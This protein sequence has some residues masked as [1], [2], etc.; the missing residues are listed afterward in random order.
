MR[1]W[2]ELSDAEFGE[3]IR[4]FIA[5][6]CPE[7]L[8]FPKRRLR[9][10]EVREWYL[11]L[12][13]EGMLAP[14]WPAEYG[15][16]GL[17]PGKALVFMETMEVNGAPRLPD[18]GIINLG[19][20]LIKH[21]NDEQ[22]QRYLPK[23]LSGEHLWCQG[24][25]EPNSGSD[26]ASLRTSAVLDGE[27]YVVNGQKIWTTWAL[28]AT[29]IFA[30]VRTDT[31]VAKQAGISFL[32]IG[33]DQPGITIR[34]IENILGQSE[35]CQ[36]FFDNARTHRSNL[37]GGVNSGWN[38]AKAL[39]GFERIWAGSPRQAQLFLAQIEDYARASGKLQDA[40]WRERIV[41]LRLDI[42]DL[43]ALYASFA[44]QV[45][46]GETLGAD[47]SILKIW[48]TE[49]CQRMSELLVDISG[50]LGTIVR[51]E[52]AASDARVPDVVTP[53]LDTRSFTIYGGTSEVQRNIV[54]RNVLD[55]LS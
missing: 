29:H 13:S 30:L 26:L 19:P 8:R 41:Q 6:H 49:T 46:R 34:P 48:A 5:R 23:I 21:G 51:D 18:Q 45:R 37:V 33:L 24:Y 53:F 9:W 11:A 50:E 40:A 36:V 14:N 22:R 16:M 1:N 39:L 28:D 15:G 2:N 7:A 4:R 43:E 55:L 31:S 17:T 3:H 10:T 47:V 27:D 54:A 20:L 12:S 38:I 44:D 52:G 35:F 42:A 25:S 32:L